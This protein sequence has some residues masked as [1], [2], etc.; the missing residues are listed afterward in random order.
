MACLRPIILVALFATTT[1]TGA[2]AQGRDGN[3]D[4]FASLCAPPLKFAAGACVPSCPGGFEDRG[5]VCVFRSQSGG[6]AGP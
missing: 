3:Q 5:R 6:N 2:L 4:A 1:A